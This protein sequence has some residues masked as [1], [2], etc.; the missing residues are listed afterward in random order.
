VLH[1]R[2]NECRG[3]GEVRIYNPVIPK[4]RLNH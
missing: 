2:C 1:Y 4:G 3:E